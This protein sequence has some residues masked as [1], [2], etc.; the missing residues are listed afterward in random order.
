MTIELIKEALNAGDNE[1]IFPEVS[2]I[3]Q[4]AQHTIFKHEIEKLRKTADEELRFQ[5]VP[6]RFSQY[7]M[8]DTT[9]SGSDYRTAYFNVRKRIDSFF[10]MY[11]LTDEEKYRV[12]LEDEIW[13]LCEM[14]TWASPTTMKGYSLNEK[15]FEESVDQAVFLDLWS[16]ETAFAL[17]EIDY[18][19]K[20]KLSG[21]IRHR[22]K[23]EVEKRVL[24]YYI[25]NDTP[26]WWEYSDNNWAAVCGGS[27]GC[28]A[29]YYIKDND[30]LAKYI[31]RV[32][33]T[34]EGFLSGYDEDGA[35]VEGVSYWNYGLSYYVYFIEMLKN[36]TGGKIDLSHTEHLHNMALFMQR[37]RIKDNLVI[38][39]ADCDPTMKFRIGFLH[40]L[41]DMFFDVQIPSLAYSIHFHDDHTYRF[42]GILRDFAWMN[43]DYITDEKDVLSEGYYFKKSQIY[44]AR[45]NDVFFGVVGGT[46]GRS[47]N[48]NDL[49]H[50]IY[51]VGN[52]GIFVDIGMG[53]Y[54]KQYFSDGRYDIINNSAKGHSLPAINGNIQL[55]GSN[56]YASDFDVN[57]DVISI[58]VTNAYEC[59]EMESLK[60]CFH[61]FENGNLEI[62]DNFELNSESNILEQFL[63]DVTKQPKPSD[64]N[65]I[66]LIKDDVY[67]QFQFDEKLKYTG[68]DKIPSNV[69]AKVPSENMYMLKFTSA[70]V[71]G[72]VNFR[73]RISAVNESR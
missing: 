72:K 51:Y 44:T 39:F 25:T 20:D 32:L 18:I 59:R 43:P 67:V 17:A 60:R 52:K 47:H 4:N 66:T 65:S 69:M 48:H 16:T 5:P 33:N 36:R 3:K 28:A 23:E 26:F 54:T 7:K 70:G 21:F 45:K 30:I 29:I 71:C 35:C 19:L 50:F 61:F 34:L 24:S 15:G 55:A 14:Y 38:N 68:Y 8:Y 42:A 46:N 64:N 9:G 2:K 53:A 31:L 13:M 40:K 27:V 73:F 10:M 22:M 12:A 56:H 58:D 41:K 57:C 62:E 1:V 37:S 11:F 49:G 63:V 6:P